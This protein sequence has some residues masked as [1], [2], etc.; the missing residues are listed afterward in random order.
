ML[1][2]LLSMGRRMCLVASSQLDSIHSDL[3]CHFYYTDQ[4][5]RIAFPIFSCSQNSEYNSDSMKWEHIYEFWKK[6]KTWAAELLQM[7][8]LLQALSRMVSSHYVPM[9][10]LAWGSCHKG[11][12]SV[13]VRWGLHSLT[14][15][16][17]IVRS[18]SVHQMFLKAQP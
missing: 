5:S 1:L 12:G 17:L 16:F 13:V 10:L 3:V 2:V 6:S 11:L 8:F 7:L 18:P 9:L 4:N 15:R 14:N